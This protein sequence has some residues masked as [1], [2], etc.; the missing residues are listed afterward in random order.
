MSAS[1]GEILV[2]DDEPHALALL[3]SILT[4]E[5][6]QV[7][8]ADSGH[9]ALASVA[10]SPPDL[11]LLDMR[12]PD[13][14]GLEACRQLKA[15][16]GSREIPVVFISG[17]ADIE[18]RVEGL[19]LGAVDFVTKPFNRA[20][21]L[22]RVRTHLELNRLRSQL[23]KQVTLRTAELRSTVE[24][25]QSEVENR[26]RTE[27]ALRE[28]EQRF[29]TMADTAP[30]MIVTADASQRATFFSRAW[31]NFTGRT[32]EQDLGSGW[33]SGIHADDLESCTNGIAAA[34]AKRQECSLKF[35]LRRWDGEYRT[36]L[37]KGIPRFEPDGT[38]AGYVGSI[39]DITEI[40]GSQKALQESK[41][42]LQEL[43]AGLLAAQE[44]ASRELARELHD[45][46][47]QELASLATQIFI[48]QEE[49]SA[50]RGLA[51]RLSELGQKSVQL[52]HS[53]H[54]TS[55]E[56]HP[57][58][59]EDLGLRVALADECDSFQERSRIR[60]TF[61]A[62]NVPADLPKEVSVCLY[63]VAQETLR[64]I[65]KHAVACNAVQ[66]LL[67]GSLKGVI[68]RIE[69]NGEGFDLKDAQRKGGLGLISIEE[70]V[71]L[72]NGSLSIRSEAG[73]GSTL[74]VVIP[75]GI[76][77]DREAPAGSPE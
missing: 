42:R 5:G 22:A 75:I 43:T 69:D 57:T 12:M 15:R 62:E 51:A 18:A 27:L 3:T 72:V 53:L 24:A 30:V 6:Y 26:V 23:E 45:V 34:F 48:L 73:R 16:A 58:I 19:E 25:L 32:M 46:F 59:L 9:L 56:L 74:E 76:P 65:G 63:R 28:S 54:R 31:L 2:V 37:C 52:A 41:Q 35:R 38:L 61:T 17:S 68:L 39:V 50:N 4:Q 67:S 14:D 10:T 8:P 71:R 20:E 64:N 7:R 11:I 77:V 21:L 55:R 33:T 49:S 66:V 1:K 13:M 29:R 47:S 36:V 44:N 40:E 70:R 60:T